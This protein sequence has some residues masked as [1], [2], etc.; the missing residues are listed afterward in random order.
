MSRCELK[1][2]LHVHTTFSDGSRSVGDILTDP[3]R[4]GLD[5]LG[6]TDHE[7][8]KAATWAGMHEGVL[9]FPGIELHN[10]RNHLLVYGVPESALVSDEDRPQRAIDAVI[11]AGGASFIAHPHDRDCPMMPAFCACPWT[12]MNVTGF[13]GIEIWNFM[14]RWKAE[15]R[16]ME[17]AMERIKD[18]IHT[19]PGPE[20][21]TMRLWDTW[22]RTRKVV[23]VGGSDAHGHNFMH[24]GRNI[25]VFPYWFMLNSIN[26]HIQLDDPLPRGNYAEAAR[27]VLA[28]LKTGASFVAHDN[29]MD[30]QGFDFR[31]ELPRNRM[32][33][34]VSRC[35]SSTVR[36]VPG[37]RDEQDLGE[38]RTLNAQDIGKAGN[39][40]KPH[41]PLRMGDETKWV[42]DLELVTECRTSAQ[43]RILRN[44]ETFQTG[45][46]FKF[47][48][49][50]N[51][52]GVY[53]IEV[54][55]LLPHVRPLR[56]ISGK[57][58]SS[59]DDT[60]GDFKAF[61]WIFSNP[62]FLR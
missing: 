26:T 19:F 8:M 24:Q 44:G 5:I 25:E 30:A 55:L 17:S 4:R 2:N 57:S 41:Y 48:C 35:G 22:S 27:R 61:P 9:V 42:Q 47:S 36:N 31:A 58:D 50:T 49:L 15:A 43:F 20:I 23:A 16:D 33:Q 1:A 45:A 10:L 62:I 13:D 6:I 7:T 18:P 34:D 14:S 28:A 51:G 40:N 59:T 53:R 21:E 38:N 29:L 11:A 52:P 39:P 46:G 56:S 60:N 3:G 32:A 12:E 37:V 54:S